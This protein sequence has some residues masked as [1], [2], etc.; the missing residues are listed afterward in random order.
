M[1]PYEIIAPHGTHT[2]H[3]QTVIF[4][5][6]A[7]Q[8]HLFSTQLGMAIL[9]VIKTNNEKWL[10]LIWKISHNAYSGIGKALIMSLGGINI[11]NEN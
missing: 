6:L 7:T 3:I 11:V 9:K 8:M 10:C 1:C 5:P 4:V 2:V